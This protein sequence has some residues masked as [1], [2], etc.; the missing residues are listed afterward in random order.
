MTNKQILK[1]VIEK[2]YKN[3]WGKGVDSQRLDWVIAHDVRFMEYQYWYSIIFSHDFAKAFWGGG[4]YRYF[5]RDNPW[6]N[7]KHYI[8]IAGRGAKQE[9]SKEE[10]DK[11]IKQSEQDSLDAFSNNL[12]RSYKTYS[13]DVKEYSWQY[14][15]QQMVLETEPLK[16]LEKFLEKGD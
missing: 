14:H 6:R 8:I 16:Y 11:N 7:R 9:V 5:V 3:G 10:Y 13:K 15:L 1:A 4:S 2:A 12:R